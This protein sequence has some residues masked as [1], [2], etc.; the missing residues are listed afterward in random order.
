MDQLS[1]KCIAVFCGSR[2]GNNSLY[3]NHTIQ[4]G[5]WMASNN[6][7]LVYGGGSVGIMG[8][9][10]DTLMKGGGNVIGVIPELL[11]NVEQGHKHITDLRIVPDMHVRKRMMYDLCDA[12][13]ILPGGNGTM[14]ELFEMVT[15][16]SLKIHSK[17]IILLNTAGYYDHLLA[18]INHSQEQG[19]LHENWR[20][21]IIVADTPEAIIG[22]FETDKS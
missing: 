20:E 5:E 22:F 4:L 12:A 14:D 10:A 21:R 18:H 7:T 16:N 1:I 8:A 17:K 9:I 15:W 6:I 11:K 3:L 2:M 19:F 13:I